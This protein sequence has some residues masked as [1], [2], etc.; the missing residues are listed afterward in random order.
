MVDFIL[1]VGIFAIVSVLCGMFFI[2]VLG[3]RDNLKS[4]AEWKLHEAYSKGLQAQE[5]ELPAHINEGEEYVITYYKWEAHS[6]AVVTK[7]Y[8]GLEME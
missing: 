4:M 7:L 5:I 6:D 8:P 3:I 2:G 1:M